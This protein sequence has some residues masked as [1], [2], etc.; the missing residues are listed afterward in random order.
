MLENTSVGINTLETFRRPVNSRVNQDLTAEHVFRG[1]KK[2]VDTMYF[3]VQPNLK[4]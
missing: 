1:S 3:E 4:Y 2:N